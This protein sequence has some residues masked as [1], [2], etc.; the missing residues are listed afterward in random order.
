MRQT[1]NALA[2]IPYLRLDPRA[3]H[4]GDTSPGSAS[5]SDP[6]LQTCTIRALWV[7]R[8][9]QIKQVSEFSNHSREEKQNIMFV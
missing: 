8:K 3:F 2:E 6:R 4:Y 1:I 7:L 5:S 9:Q